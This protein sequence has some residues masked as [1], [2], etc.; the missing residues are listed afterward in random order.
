[1]Q[2][3]SLSPVQ[4]DD[5]LARGVGSKCEFSLAAVNLR[6]V[7]SKSQKL[8]IPV[9]YLGKDDFVIG[10]SDLHVHSNLRAEVDNR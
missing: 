4:T 3:R 8:L 9:K 10:V 1:M 5:M 6:M 2:A 7:T